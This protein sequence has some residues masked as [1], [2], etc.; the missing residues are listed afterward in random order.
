VNI[1]YDSWQPFQAAWQ[2]GTLPG[3]NLIFTLFILLLFFQ[4]QPLVTLLSHFGHS[5]Q[6]FE[7][8]DNIISL[9]YCTVLE[10]IK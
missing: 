9:R 10:N 8:F 4:L 1:L 7:H 6:N 3:S 5:L 2:D